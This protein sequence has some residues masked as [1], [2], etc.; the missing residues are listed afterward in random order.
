MRWVLGDG[1]KNAGENGWNG[2]G[3]SPEIREIAGVL[4]SRV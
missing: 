1:G 3:R 4:D 2:K